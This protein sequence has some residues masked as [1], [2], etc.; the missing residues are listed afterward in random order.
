MNIMSLKD[1]K[2]CIHEKYPEKFTDEEIE[3]LPIILIDEYDSQSTT[4]SSEK[5]IVV[6][7]VGEEPPFD[8][9]TYNFPYF[10]RALFIVAF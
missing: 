3:N 9:D 6:K 8:I 10:T 7:D 5:H 4:I 2:T 1:I